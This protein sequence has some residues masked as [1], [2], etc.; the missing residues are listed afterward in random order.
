MRNYHDK[1][2]SFP[3]HAI[4][5]KDGKTPLLSWRVA[6]LPYLGRADLHDAFKL[7][8]P[9]DSEH[10]KKLIAE[11]PRTYKMG[12]STKA[13]EGET[14]YQ[15]ITGLDTVFNGAKAMKITDI[16]D[17]TANTILVVEAKTPVAWTKPEDVPM[18]KDKDKRL[19]LGGNFSN[20][21]QAVFCDGRVNLM[22]S[23]IEIPA[24]RAMITPAAGD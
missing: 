3:A 20:G 1:E 17:G 16:T 8:E 13:K 11:M 5:S 18:P 24:L 6:I 21:F 23:D 4:Y 12:G 9:W 7:D 15:V 14:F 2:N 19:P 22:A 10:N